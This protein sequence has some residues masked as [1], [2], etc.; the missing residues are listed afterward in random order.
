MTASKRFGKFDCLLEYV[1]KKRI[2]IITYLKG[3][4]LMHRCCIRG[5]ERKI[6]SQFIST[7]GLSQAEEILK[8]SIPTI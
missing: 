4:R 7:F 6:A 3:A 2:L 5:L 8:L 1:P